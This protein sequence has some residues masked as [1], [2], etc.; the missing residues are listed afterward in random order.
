MDKVRIRLLSIVIENL[1]NVSHGQ[2][3]LVNDEKECKAS[4]LGLY[5]QSASGKTVLMNALQLLKYTLC[6]KS[7]PACFA[8]Y[9]QIGADN[10]KIQCTFSMQAEK[11][12]YEV[13]YE[14]KIRRE[15]D[16]VLQN[17]AEFS[18]EEN[19]KVV[20][21]DEVLSYYFN[22]C[23]EEVSKKPIIDI[24]TQVVFESEEIYECLCGKKQENAVE[25]AV[26]KKLATASSRSFIFSSELISMIRQRVSCV[27]KTKEF[28]RCLLLLES[29]IFY[30]NF[31][32]FVVGTDDVGLNIPPFAF[33]SE[34]EECKVFNGMTLP[35]EDSV[36]ISQDALCI[37]KKVIDSMNVV[38]MQIVPEF[39]LGV[40][41]FGIQVLKSGKIGNKIQLVSYRDN[42]EIMLKYESEG[43]KR[44]VSVLQVLIAIY[45][46]PS[47][48]VAIDELGACVFERLFE[49][50][51]K[52]LSEKGQGQLIFTS[53]NT[54]PLETLD[55][56]FTTGDPVNRYVRIT[57]HGIAFE[58][59]GKKSH[60][61]VMDTKMTQA[62]EQAWQL[63]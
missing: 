32:F 27:S 39:T 48:T 41:D 17:T 57:D 54:R 20:L 4:I 10:A 30:G 19:Y 62:F 53:Q 18:S 34:K 14:F 63:L 3:N 1:K 38:L 46:Q 13:F 44:I 33:R 45:N 15:M 50:I 42:K 59:Q 37:V 7:I 29:L 6:G 43:I 22:S 55:Q 21:F 51:L 61:F 52:V 25:L 2:L 11:C 47:I 9:V 8:D 16:T 24:K 56:A 12:N 26:A 60:S 23:H 49:E 40:K 5:G 58:E 28:D 31:E 36:V 35:I